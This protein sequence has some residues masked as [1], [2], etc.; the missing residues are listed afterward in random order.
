MASDSA[1][2]D[3]IQLPLQ[4]ILASLPMELRAKIMGVKYHGMAISIP[5]EKA[6][7]QLATGSVKISFGELRQLAPGVFANS[8]GELDAKMVSLPL[9]QIL[10]QLNPA[11]LARRSAKKQV[12][13]S[14]DISS[15]FD[16]RGQGLKISTEPFKAQPV[17]PVPEA[18]IA[19]VAIQPAGFRKAR[20]AA[21]RRAAAGFHAALDNAIRQPNL[22]RAMATAT[23]PTATARP[24]PH[25]LFQL[26]LFRV[27]PP[28]QFLRRR[29]CRGSRSRRF[30]RRWPRFP[31]TGRS[32]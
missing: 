3:E 17:T 32:R 9:N 1:N 7:A 6:L 29:F 15:P 8:G 4:P 26:R 24:K 31:N 2:P 30:P 25:Y 5:V 13:I 23:V 19:D 16:A 12:E 18:P 28:H 20:P 27:H 10:A 11:L 14:D 22:R 21:A